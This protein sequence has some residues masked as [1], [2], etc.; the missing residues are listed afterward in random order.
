MNFVYLPCQIKKNQAG[1][2]RT[3]LVPGLQLRHIRWFLPPL[4]RLRLFTIWT[5][6]FEILKNKKVCSHVKNEVWQKFYLSITRVNIWPLKYLLAYSITYWWYFW[7]FRKF[8]QSIEY[9]HISTY[10][11]ITKKSAESA[12]KFRWTDIASYVRHELR[13]NHDSFLFDGRDIWK[14]MISTLFREKKEK[15]SLTLKK[16]KRS[17]F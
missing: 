5:Q 8:H 14:N 6:I 3:P 10:F 15:K 1:G 2:V 16:Y 12:K 4:N 17:P 11:T 13:N 7:H 9:L